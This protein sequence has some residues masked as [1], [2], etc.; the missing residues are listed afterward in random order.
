M[1]RTAQLVADLCLTYRID[2][3]KLDADQLRANYNDE[4]VSGVCGHDDVSRVLGGTHWDPGPNFPWLD[5]MLAVQGYRELLIKE[6]RGT[7]DE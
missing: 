3:R 7:I 4:H 2:V 1:R 6:G 5:F